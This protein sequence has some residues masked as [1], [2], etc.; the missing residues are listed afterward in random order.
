MA[1]G[2]RAGLG[3]DFFADFLADFLSEP[4]AAAA[5]LLSA[6]G[7]GNTSP[8]CCIAFDAL[9]AAS[10]AASARR[11]PSSYAIARPSSAGDFTVRTRAASSARYLSAAVPLPPAI[12]AP[13]W[14]MRLPG[15]AVTPAI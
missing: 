6:R 12:T 2:L 11:L 5:G 14:P 15:G 9:L 1:T 10:F 8:A 4:L 7:R 13:A 3:G